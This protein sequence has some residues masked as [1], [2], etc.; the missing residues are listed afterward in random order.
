MWISPLSCLFSSSPS[1]VGLKVTKVL[2]GLVEIKNASVITGCALIKN[3]NNIPLV[4]FLFTA[5]EFHYVLLEFRQVG[6]IP[7]SPIDLK[8]FTP[9]FPILINYSLNILWILLI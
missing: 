8:S 7:L 9:S 3:W 2:K 6:K 1:G 5:S 4:N